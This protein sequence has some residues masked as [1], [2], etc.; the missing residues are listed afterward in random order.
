MKEFVQASAVLL[1]AALYWAGGQEIPWLNTGL[2]WLRR[3]AMPAVLLAACL[4]LGAVWYTAILACVLL[5]L[6]THLG[7][8]NRVY[9]YFLTGF[10][11]GAPSIFIAPVA[12]QIP[13]ALAP[14]VV[15]GGFGL[16]SRMSNKFEWSWV[17]LITGI[18]IGIAFVHAAML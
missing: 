9:L 1:S 12:A 2:K 4:Y 8:K 16:L 3:F 7:Y 6:A 11:M 5:C 14:C 15:H 17:A 18:S 10:C 13:Y